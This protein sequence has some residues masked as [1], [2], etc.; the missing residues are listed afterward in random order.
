MLQRKIRPRKKGEQK[1]FKNNLQWIG[2][3]KFPYFTGQLVTGSEVLSHFSL[4]DSAVNKEL[5][6]PLHIHS[7]TSHLF[8]LK[9]L[10]FLSG[11]G[12]RGSV[13]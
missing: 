9:L 5:F 1:S 7:G 13:F 8:L 10:T 4:L 3:L 11:L 6:G 2:Q 12:V